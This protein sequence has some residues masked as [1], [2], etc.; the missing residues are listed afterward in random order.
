MLSDIQI[1]QQAE[2]A[3]DGKCDDT[4]FPEGLQI[5]FPFDQAVQ[6]QKAHNRQRHLQHHQL[7]CLIHQMHVIYHL[8]YRG[9]KLRFA[10]HRIIFVL[11]NLGI[12]QI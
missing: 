9:Y 8:V 1:A 12:H 10:I 6:G 4:L 5:V 11:L 3:G 7:L 2:S